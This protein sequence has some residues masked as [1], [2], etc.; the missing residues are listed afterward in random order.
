MSITSLSLLGCLAAATVSTAAWTLQHNDPR[1]TSARRAPVAAS[2]EAAPKI[3]VLDAVTNTR[4][5]ASD[6]ETI[7]VTG[8]HFSPKTTARIVSPDGKIFTFGPDAFE[9]RTDASFT[10][11]PALEAPGTYFLMARSADGTLSNT[12]KFQVKR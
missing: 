8:S 6:I 11:T 12:V 10:L 5:A 3:P 1:E 2:T 4:G 7:T 9:K